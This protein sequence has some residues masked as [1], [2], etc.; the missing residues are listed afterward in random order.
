MQG[1]MQGFAQVCRA[2]TGHFQ[3]SS[4]CVLPKMSLARQMLY[5]N[6]LC[7]PVVVQ[8]HYFCNA[9]MSSSKVREQPYGCATHTF[10]AQHASA[11]QFWGLSLSPSLSLSLSL[12]IHVIYIDCICMCI[13]YVYTHMYI[14]MYTDQTLEG[15]VT[16]PSAGLL[17]R[18]NSLLPGRRRHCSLTGLLL[19]NLVTTIKKAYAF[20]I[21]PHHGHLV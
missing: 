9:K 11:L 10:G 13:L 20:G 21:D 18:A 16:V 8:R 5:R 4:P 1:F 3:Y 17:C 15:C 14:Y 19:A 12:Y 6:S 7:G 2:R